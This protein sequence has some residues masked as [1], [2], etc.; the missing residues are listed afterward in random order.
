MTQLILAALFFTGLHFGVAGTSL[1]NVLV[2][3]LGEKAYRIA[4]SILSLLGLVWLA[5]AYSQADYIE[6]WGQLTALK[7][8]AAPLVLIGFLFLVLGLTTP[9][10]TSVRNEDLLQGDA[11]AQGVMRITRH[12]FLWG[13]ALWAFAHLLVNGD[14]ASLVFFGSFLLL[15]L[16]G[17][18][19]IDAKRQQRYGEHWQHFAAVTSVIPFM[20]IWQGRNRLVFSEFKWWPVAAA[21]AAYLVVAHFHQTLFGVAPM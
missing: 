7:P 12:P 2:D 21:L 15:V 6:T 19:S 14:L 20:A 17:M 1:R 5:R 11:P 18:R 16:G 8:L 13:V 10:P 4:F 3:K 9:N